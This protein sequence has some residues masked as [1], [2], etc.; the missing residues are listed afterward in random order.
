MHVQ[1][2]YMSALHDNKPTTYKH[3]DDR[4]GYGQIDA[5]DTFIFY[6]T[7][8]S[9]W[10]CFSQRVIGRVIGCS[11]MIGIAFKVKRGPPKK[12]NR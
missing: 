9:S 11:P 7:G 6:R 5:R 10:S 1:N 2:L 3:T 8:Q 12:G 4:A